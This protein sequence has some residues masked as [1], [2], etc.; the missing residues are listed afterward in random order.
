MTTRPIPQ[1]APNV[2]VTHAQKLSVVCPRCRARVGSPCFNEVSVA[3]YPCE[4]PHKE[5]RTAF[6]EHNQETQR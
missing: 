6:I 4:E 3:G 1:V 5:R 2:R